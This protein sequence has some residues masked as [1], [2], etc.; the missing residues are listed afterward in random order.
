MAKFTTNYNLDLYEAG[1]LPNL[2][3]QYNGAMGKVDTALASINTVATAAGTTASGAQAAAAAAQTAA[4]GAQTKADAA[5]ALA[6]TNESDIASLETTVQQHTT[7]ISALNDD[8]SELGTQVNQ[9]ASDITE[10]EHSIQTIGASHRSSGT[11]SVPSTIQGMTVS[12]LAQSIY[13]DTAL[14]IASMALRMTLRNTT[15]AEIAVA[16]GTT[17][18][19]L[20]QGF[21]P[22]TQRILECALVQFSTDT[23]ATAGDA[24]EYAAPMYARINTDGTVIALDSSKMPG[25][26]R[27]PATGNVRINAIQPCIFTHEWG[28]NY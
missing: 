18:F 24:N 14:H 2:L 9:N 26:I 21:A 11:I 1:D 16:A 13:K 20:P 25:T 6:Q 4:E 3:D 23:S 19:T 15:E 27:V 12:T 7:A 5:T 10:L 17:L 28:A 8:V 22:S